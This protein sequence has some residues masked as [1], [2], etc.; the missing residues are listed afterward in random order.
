MS[1]DKNN[2]SS[3]I[4]DDDDGV[5]IV[6]KL[7]EGDKSDRKVTNRV[8]TSRFNYSLCIYVLFI[9]FYF[10]PFRTATSARTTTNEYGWFNSFKPTTPTTT[11]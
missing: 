6:I 9:F 10:F 11:F 7:D 5:D 1:S 8:F 3:Q 2:A 4:D